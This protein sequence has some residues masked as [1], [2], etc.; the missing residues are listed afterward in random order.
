MRIS[1]PDFAK[2]RSLFKSLHQRGCFVMPNPWDV[3]SA[4]Y[5]QHLGFKA[6]ATTSG[7]F[8]FSQGLPD[9]AWAVPCDSMLSNIGDIVRAVDLPV[10]ADFES[11]YSDAPDGI[12]E[13]VR[14]CIGTGVAGLSI[15]DKTA[16][17]ANALYELPL[18]V[19]RIRAAREAIDASD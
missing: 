17:P 4:L 19:E 15:E 7:G 6:L 1:N 12:A 3:G 13:N 9:A 14:F 11:G 18:A 5:L 8:A 10:N 16:D 2:R